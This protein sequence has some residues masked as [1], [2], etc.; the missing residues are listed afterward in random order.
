MTPHGPAILVL[1]IGN[2]LM[3]DDGVG[4]RLMEAL[5]TLEPALPGVE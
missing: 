4:V 3:R 5:A 1:G 2:T